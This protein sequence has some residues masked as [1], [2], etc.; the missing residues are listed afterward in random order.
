[1]ITARGAGVLGVCLLLSA[2]SGFLGTAVLAAPAVGG[3]VTLGAA[4]LLVRAAATTGGPARLDRATVTRGEPATLTA[5]RPAVPAWIP[6]T[7]ELLLAREASAAQGPQRSAGDPSAGD[8]SAGDGEAL[9]LRLA[10]DQ[11]GVLTLGPSVLRVTDPLELFRAES[12]TVDALTLR[13]LPRT[14]PVPG[15]GAGRIRTARFAGRALPHRDGPEFHALREYRP[16]DDVRRIH[17]ASSA[18]TATLLVRED[19]AVREPTRY[20]WLDTRAVCYPDRAS[21]EEAVDTAASLAADCA[22]RGLALRLWT[23][24]GAVLNTSPG[25]SGRARSLEFLTE[26]APTG[27]FPGRGRREPPPGADARTGG[28]PPRGP[29]RV[30]ARGLLTVVTGGSA[31][32]HALPTPT[33]GGCVVVA[34]H[35]GTDAPRAEESGDGPIR[36][37]APVRHRHARDAEQALLL[38]AAA[39]RAP[40]RRA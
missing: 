16:G 25:P 18:R 21:F 15:A 40:G 3:L 12:R 34:L 35:L 5:D 26:V 20:V 14:L 32:G 37:A 28:A 29:Y 17:W 4:A 2:C 38:W 22:R 24:E 11:H 39:T 23:S 7:C 31:A 19:T 27:S 8:P 6:L 33:T 36:G 13:V 10:T 30:A 1:M 9:V